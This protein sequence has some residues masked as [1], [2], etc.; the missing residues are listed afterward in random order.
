M[1]LGKTHVQ[2]EWCLWL[3]AGGKLVRKS[4]ASEE[5]HINSHTAFD[6]QFGESK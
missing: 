6:L 5:N 4:F 1:I 3:F 2:T